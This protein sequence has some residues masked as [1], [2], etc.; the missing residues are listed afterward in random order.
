MQTEVN[1]FLSL[2]AVMVSMGQ[3]CAQCG[4]LHPRE[5]FPGESGTCRDCVEREFAPIQ[6][7]V[8]EMRNRLDDLVADRKREERQYA[9]AIYPNHP[10]NK[11]SFQ[12]MLAEEEAYWLRCELLGN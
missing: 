10:A 9:R 7:S 1:R 3:F 12:E 6:A 2:F 5:A 8:R 11:P 4:E